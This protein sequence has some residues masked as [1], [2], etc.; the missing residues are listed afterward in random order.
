M[1]EDREPK[2]ETEQPAPPSHKPG[3]TELDEELDAIEKAD[4]PLWKE[5]EEELDRLEL[6]EF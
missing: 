1:S 6:E 5:F 2:T 3:R 4:G